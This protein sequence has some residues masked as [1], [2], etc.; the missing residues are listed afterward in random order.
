MLAA[1]AIA[2][3]ALPK[4]LRL[5]KVASDTPAS[6]HADAC[7]V[8]GRTNGDNFQHQD[9]GLVVHDMC[10]T[11]LVDM[12]TDPHDTDAMQCIH[13]ISQVV[14]GVMNHMESRRLFNQEERG[15]IPA[16]AFHHIFAELQRCKFAS[17][18]DRRSPS[19]SGSSY[20][21]FVPLCKALMTALV[22]RAEATRAAT[23]ACNTKR[24]EHALSCPV[25]VTGQ[26]MPSP[27][28]LASLGKG[29]IQLV[30]PLWRAYIAGEVTLTKL[31]TKKNIQGVT[32][33][34]RLI[35]FLL[36]FMSSGERIGP[37]GKDVDKLLD[38]AGVLV[39]SASDARHAA[40][41]RADAAAAAAASHASHIQQTQAASPSRKRRAAG[42]DADTVHGGGGGGGGARLDMAQCLQYASLASEAVSAM[43]VVARQCG[44]AYPSSAVASGA[45][46]GVADDA[47][48]GA[49]RDVVA[50]LAQ[51][52][53]ASAAAGA[54]DDTVATTVRPD[55]V[56]CTHATPAGQIASWEF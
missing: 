14:G 37:R 18:T 48:C 2:A 7:H 10:A 29:I 31:C 15:H 34:V 13:G 3:A 33:H 51:L 11:Y 22:R 45:Y 52:V 38:D 50:Q 26:M 56:K 39:M 9:G 12:V 47:R 28:E 8:C 25:V 32:D 54:K 42:A 6:A 19:G 27:H 1:R 46:S 4:Y 23:L 40:D 21:T 41:A 44:V 53:A 24:D 35:L 49:L 5:F 36:K 30:P 17:N 16:P 20:A 43:A 55:T